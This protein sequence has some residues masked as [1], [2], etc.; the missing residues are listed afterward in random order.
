MS[1]QSEFEQNVPWQ[2]RRRFVIVVIAFC[3]GCIG[4]VLHYRLESEIA[5]TVVT[6]AF[7]TIIATLG[8][9]VFGATW[10]DVKG[11]KR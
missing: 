8:S 7:S 5:E 10:S 2:N 11:V 6:M 4:Y 9:Y 1:E 3:M